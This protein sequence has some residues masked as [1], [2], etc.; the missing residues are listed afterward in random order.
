MTRKKRS[1][2]YNMDDEVIIGYNVK[3]KKDKTTKKQKKP[4]ITNNTKQ[5]K[6]VIIKNII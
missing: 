2:Q 4:K 3:L 6:K 1:E 5:P